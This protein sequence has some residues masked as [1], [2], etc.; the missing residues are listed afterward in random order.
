VEEIRA[1]LRWTLDED[2]VHF[3]SSPVFNL[4]IQDTL[5]SLAVS[6]APGSD[7]FNVEF[8]KNS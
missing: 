2:Q 8:F 3:L 4:E 7:G 5:F 1:V 6:K